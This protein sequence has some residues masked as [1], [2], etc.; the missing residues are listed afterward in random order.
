VLGSEARS[1]RRDFVWCYAARV[2]TGSTTPKDDEMELKRTWQSGNILVLLAGLVGA[3]IPALHLPAQ[4]KP[5]SVATVP[6]SPKHALIRT[7]AGAWE[8]RASLWLGPDAKPI[9][10]SAVARRRLIGDTLLEEVMTPSPGSDGPA[11]TRLAFL[12]YNAVRSSYEYVSWD[13][14]AP[15]MMYQVSRAIG[16]PESAR[17]QASSG[18]IWSTISWCHSGVMPRTLHSSSD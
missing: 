7:M 8:V 6:S 1:P 11:F 10:Q 2:G 3:G 4:E 18:S 13:T 14:R 5:S 9:V 15:Q 12:N 17:G 16:T